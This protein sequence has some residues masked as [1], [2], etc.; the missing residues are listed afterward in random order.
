MLALAGYKAGG[1]Q[2]TWG[3][4][5]QWIPG[6]GTMQH[7]AAENITKGS[8]VGESIKSHRN[9]LAK[10][11]I[12]GTLM[13]AGGIIAAPHLAA[14]TA[15]TGTGATAAAGTAAGTG[16]GAAAVG[17]TAVGTTAATTAAKTGTAAVGKTVAADAVTDVGSEAAK[18]MTKSDYLKEA[19]DIYNKAG[20][21][22]TKGFGGWLKRGIDEGDINTQT[23]GAYASGAYKGYY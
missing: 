20:G 12:I 2:N 13:A 21:V 16:T 6:L 15:A 9:Q 23:T 8:D 17:G 4:V 3:K 11:Q 5:T 10:K 1:E 19:A 18:N 7:V 14:G 22:D